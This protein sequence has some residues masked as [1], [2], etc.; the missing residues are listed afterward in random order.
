MIPGCSLRHSIWI[1]VKVE[2]LGLLRTFW[3]SIWEMQEKSAKTVQFELPCTNSR[4]V[5]RNYTVRHEIKL[6]IF[7]SKCN[8]RG[9]GSGINILKSLI[10]IQNFEYP[11]QFWLVDCHCSVLVIVFFLCYYF[12]IGPLI[13]FRNIS[14]QM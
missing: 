4:F 2:S 11:D 5:S 6:I 14:L 9:D 7:Q 8:D 3:L 12:I 10:S 13:I 1:L